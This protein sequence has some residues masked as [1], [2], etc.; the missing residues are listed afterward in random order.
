[1]LPRK[2]GA[3][4]SINTSKEPLHE[5]ILELTGGRRPDVIIEAIGLPETFRSAVEEVA[6]TGRVV[7]IG[8]A[9]EPVAYETKLFVM[10]ELD[11]LGSRNALPADFREVIQML[12]Q[13]RFPVEEAV[14]HMISIDEA[15]QMLKAWSENPAAYSKIMI[16]LD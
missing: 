1:A 2:A 3:T 10:K 12:E 15:P 5:K 11:I 13:H 8:Y 6:F 7:Y 9:K 4:D 16:T 14:I